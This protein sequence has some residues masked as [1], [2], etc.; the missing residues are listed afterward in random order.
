MYWLSFADPK[1]GARGRPGGRPMKDDSGVWDGEVPDTW[2]RVDK[3]EL[4]R[5]V[6][7][8]RES[9]T[10]LVA[11]KF[12]RKATA[13]AGRVLNTM[14]SFPH[15]VDCVDPLGLGIIDNKTFRLVNDSSESTRV[16]K[17]HIDSNVCEKLMYFSENLDAKLFLSRIHQ[18]T[19]PAADLEAGAL[20]LKNR[21]PRA[22]SAEETIG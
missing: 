3:A 12:E 16:E 5:W 10:A 20:A 22:D 2:K 18:D 4:A 21:S 6:R 7:E 19:P 9:R 14:Q 13:P 8:M 11:Q 17:D 15:S 1:G